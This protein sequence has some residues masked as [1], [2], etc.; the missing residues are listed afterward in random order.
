MYIMENILT[1]L[2]ELVETLQTKR[3]N[4]ENLEKDITKFIN[5]KGQFCSGHNVRTLKNIIDGLFTIVKEQDKRIS[6]LE[7]KNH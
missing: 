5:T 1:E 6:K 3:D 7:F 2:I 4:L